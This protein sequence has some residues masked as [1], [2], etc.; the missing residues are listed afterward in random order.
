MRFEEFQAEIDWWGS[1]ADDFAARVE[2]E[3]AWKVTI[4]E[5]RARNYNLD[6]KNPHVG[7][8]INHDPEELLAK[9]AK[10]QKEIQNIRDQLKTILAEAL[11]DGGAARK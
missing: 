9:Y 5:I 10:Q 1:E 8:Q 11:N 2:T 6:I 7:E 4:D 3:Q